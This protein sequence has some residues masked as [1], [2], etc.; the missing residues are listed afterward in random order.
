MER[1]PD[2]G[3][4]LYWGPKKGPYFRELPILLISHDPEVYGLDFQGL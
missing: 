4:V 1:P 3:A 2:K